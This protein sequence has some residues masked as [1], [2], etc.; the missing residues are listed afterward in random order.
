MLD[1]HSIIGTVGYMGGVMSVPE[2]F[3][4]A[5]GNMLV[6]SHEALCQPGEHIHPDRTKFSLHDWGRNDLVAR[7]KGDWIFMLDTDCSFEPDLCARMVATMYRHDVEILTG[8]YSF[9]AEPHLP[10][11]Y[12]WNEKTERHEIVAKWDRTRWDGKNEIFQVDSAG[13]GCLLV[14]RRVFERITSEL[15]ENPFSRKEAKGEDHSFFMRTR[16]LGI[17]AYCAWKIEVQHL[18]YLGITPSEH[19]EFLDDNALHI[20]SAPEGQK[21]H[22]WQ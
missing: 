17:K 8:I 7:M 22:S 6:Y 16:Q 9:K 2:P 10:V 13:G 4:F 1:R 21:E 5:W 11:L 20:L 3:T 18:E 12:I 19:Y 15:K 14:R